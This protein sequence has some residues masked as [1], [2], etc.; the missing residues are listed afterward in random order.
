MDRELVYCTDLW[1]DLKDENRTVFWH[2]IYKCTE[3]STSKHPFRYEVF[4][5]KREHEGP[6][7]LN[8]HNPIYWSGYFDNEKVTKTDLK[9]ALY[10][11]EGAKRFSKS[12]LNALKN[13]KGKKS[14]I[15]LIDYESFKMKLEEMSNFLNKYTQE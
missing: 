1:V 11:E 2:E 3:P 15:V 13:K 9:Q 10:W 4:I 14:M 5:C 6:N 7:E 12:K 8:V